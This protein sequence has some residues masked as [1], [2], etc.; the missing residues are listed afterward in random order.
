MGSNPT[1]RTNSLEGRFRPPKATFFEGGFQ[2]LFAFVQEY[3]VHL[4]G[5]V[6]KKLSKL[7]RIDN[8]QNNLCSD[9]LCIG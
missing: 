1:T 5:K 2:F 4:C 7:L 9:Y 8:G 3:F 6:V